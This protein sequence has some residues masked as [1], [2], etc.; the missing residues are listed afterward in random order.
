MP[1]T[2]LFVQ[3]SKRVRTAH[4]LQECSSIGAVF[5]EHPAEVRTH[6]HVHEITSHA[7]AHEH[8]ACDQVPDV[9]LYLA[10]T[11]LN[12]PVSKGKKLEFGLFAGRRRPAGS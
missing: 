1:C 5:D 8:V 11:K 10:P 12:M 3:V 6:V 2:C 7:Y 9:D 4:S